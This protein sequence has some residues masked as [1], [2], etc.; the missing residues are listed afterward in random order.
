MNARMRIVL[1]VIAPAIAVAGG[2]V[3]EATAELLRGAVV[4][5]GGNISSGGGLVLHATVGQPIV[6][7]DANASTM[8]CYGYWCFGGPRVLAVDPPDPGP[9]PRA[10]PT[11]LEL[12]PAYP[13]PSRGAVGFALALPKAAEVRV[14]AFDVTGRRAG[15]AVEAS[16][17]AGWHTLRWDAPG[18]T[19]GGT[20][21]YFVR[22]FVDGRLEGERRVV[23]LR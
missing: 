8:A 19:G 13:N 4:A 6:G 9:D 7:R 23:T 12:G 2:V 5:N 22:L 17:G 15:P 3:T 18:A 11:R 10:L 16:L 1:L 20:G 14:E 21:L